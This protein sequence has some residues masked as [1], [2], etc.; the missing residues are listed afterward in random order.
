MINIECI[1]YLWTLFPL[2]IRFGNVAFPPKAPDRLVFQINCIDA[3]STTMNSWPVGSIRQRSFVKP[4]LV[5]RFP[6]TFS[7][8]AFSF[9]D[10][11][12]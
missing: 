5:I 8:E 12:D 3:Y 6:C 11:A 10:L 9:S 2:K 7:D 4:E 1:P